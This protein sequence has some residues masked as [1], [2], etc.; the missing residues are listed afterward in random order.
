[1]ELPDSLVT[2]VRL[3]RVVLFLGAGASIGATASGK[4]P[5]LASGLRDALSERFLSG[6]M[7]D[8]PLAVVGEL[9]I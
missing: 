4:K 6:N 5:L 2:D 3:G 7:N 9:A 8:D 1:M